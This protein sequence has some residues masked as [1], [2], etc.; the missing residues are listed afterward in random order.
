MTWQ[1][2]YP[3][4]PGSPY[5]TLASGI[6]EDDTSISLTADP[7]FA[8]ATNLACIWD[9][10]G[11]FEVVKYTDLTG[12][13]LTV[14]RGFEGTAQAWSAGAYIANL[15]PAYAINSLQ[16]NIDELNSGKQP[17]DATL[18][19]LAGVTTAANKLPYATG[20]DAFDVCDF[21]SFGRSLIGTTTASAVRDL[22]ASVSSTTATQSIYVDKAATGTGTGVDWTNAFTTIQAAVDSLPA[23]INHAVTIYIRKGS[24]PYRETVTVQRVIGAGSILIRG[25]YYWN[26]Q[27]GY[28]T[29]T[30]EN[31]TA[32]R[33]YK[34]A[35]DDFT[36]VENG[37]KVYLL[38]YSGTYAAS[39]PT[40]SYVGTVTDA[41]TKASGY[42]T[43]SMDSSVTP[44]TAWHYVIC[45]TEISGSN[46][47][48]TPT[49]TFCFDIRSSTNIYGLILTLPSARAINCT[50]GNS[51]IYYCILETGER[52]GIYIKGKS[53]VGYVYN[54]S[55]TGV[56]HSAGT[57]YPT[58]VVSEGALCFI[59]YCRV[60][61]TT[62]VGYTPLMGALS[63][64][65]AK[66][67][68]CDLRS[69]QYSTSG[70]G[71]YSGLSGVVQ[72]YFSRIKGHDG[73]NKLGTGI[74][75]LSGSQVQ[76]S[77]NTIDATT[78]V[79]TAKTPATWAATTDGSYI[80]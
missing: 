18:T 10:T 4:T 58:G 45:K 68:Y 29:G 50:S 28:V 64:G 17:L 78:T 6:D 30:T 39:V 24:T 48:T 25:E 75:A 61:Q 13:T 73:S 35:S 14:E 1:T 9:D 79:T 65:Y 55:I 60:L 26:K 80:Q 77:D 49:R 54:C 37:D 42:V 56:A 27:T 71:I 34:N 59:R 44:T 62:T 53:I 31:T 40:N 72:L 8:A 7:G 5:T 52:S 76:Q 57:N 46:N 43:I 12:T 69:L 20:E 22:I 3:A 2:M 32:N 16:N 11:N 15:I 38:Q 41:S 21:T 66:I 74:F 67:E 70:S 23:I 36:N 33:L 19:A 51:N 63:Q 47:G